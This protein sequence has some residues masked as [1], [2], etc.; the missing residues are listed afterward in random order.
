MIRGIWIKTISLPSGNCKRDDFHEK[1][2]GAKIE[3]MLT[4]IRYRFYRKGYYDT[5]LTD[6][7]STEH[8]FPQAIMG[9]A[10]APLVNLNAK[11]F[12]SPVLVM[13]YVLYRLL[14]SP[15]IFVYYNLIEKLH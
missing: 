6:S 15:I 14:G 12:K 1:L 4:V 7:Y 8:R 9:S 13:K 3:K 5:N 2:W 11:A 10:T